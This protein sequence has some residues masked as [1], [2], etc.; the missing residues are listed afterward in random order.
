MKK[1][2]SVSFVQYLLAFALLLV[3]AVAIGLY[4]PVTASADAVN[5]IEIVSIDEVAA[6]HFTYTVNVSV[7]S[8]FAQARYGIG[9]EYSTDSSFMRSNNRPVYIGRDAGSYN[10]FDATSLRRQF[11][12]YSVDLVPHVHYWVRPFLY[13]S[14]I[15]MNSSDLI[16]GPVVEF[17]GP[18]DDSGYLSLQMNQQYNMRQFSGGWLHGKFTAPETG[19]YALVGYNLDDTSPS[20]FDTIGYMTE[21][22]MGGYGSTGKAQ[23]NTSNPLSIIRYLMKDETIYLSGYS[24]V[25]DD[26]VKVI[27]GDEVL[28][29]MA[30]DSPE[31]ARNAALLFVAPSAGWYDFH[32][33]N[34]SWNGYIRTLDMS[35]GQWYY[36]G[37]SF[38]RYLDAGEKLYVRP[39]NNSNPQDNNILNRLLVTNAVFPSRDTVEISGDPFEVTNISASFPIT[40]EIT[41]ETIRNGCSFG[42]MYGEGTDPEQWTERVKSG[43]T[44]YNI[45]Y[46]STNFGH[47]GKFFPGQEFYYQGVLFDSTNKVIARDPAIHHMALEDN[48]NGLPELVM[49]QSAEWSTSSTAVYYF[50]APENGVYTVQGDGMISIRLAT[51]NS[52]FLGVQSEQS[53]Y[54][55]EVYLRQGQKLYINTFNDMGNNCTLTVKKS[56]DLTRLVFPSSLTELQDEACMG[57]PVQQVVFSTEIQR[58]GSRAFADCT[59]L[60]VVEIPGMSVNIEGDAFE[61][62][63]HVVLMAPTG[64][65]AETFATT[66]SNVT[67]VPIN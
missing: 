43:P 19:F 6:D 49:G 34:R 29:R 53:S 5:S 65:T 45:I 21:G 20:H 56:G 52:Q 26:Y 33:E 57:L 32:F 42:I 30:L 54:Q 4:H 66:H 1:N 39:E 2:H 62:C 48:V 38:F 23:G 61:N 55:F 63:T 47:R 58:I 51:E 35:N 67:F 15:S 7:T 40:M 60:A 22:L 16:Y 59:D 13:N 10:D 9:I 11:V 46:T 50:T 17:D 64:S 27:S 41:E 37:Q 36:L 12:R 31:S 25:I 8:E 3:S 14:S 24:P 44:R 18:A 28:P